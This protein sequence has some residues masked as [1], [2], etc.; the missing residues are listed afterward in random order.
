MYEE[1][2]NLF[3]KTM[4][5]EF[6]LMEPDFEDSEIESWYDEN[7]ALWQEKVDEASIYMENRYLLDRIS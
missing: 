2:K 1:F 6:G 5:I 4:E 3:L 7:K